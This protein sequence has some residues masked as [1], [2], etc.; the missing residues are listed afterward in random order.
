MGEGGG[1]ADGRGKVFLNY[2]TSPLGRVAAKPTGECPLARTVIANVVKQSVSIVVRFSARLLRLKPRNDCVLP[3]PSLRENPKDFRG[4][5]LS[6][7]Q[8][9]ASSFRSS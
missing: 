1:E 8:E 5:L 2:S 6:Y 3:I 7:F 9:I 4:N